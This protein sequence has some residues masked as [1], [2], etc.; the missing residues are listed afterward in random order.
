[1]KLSAL[2]TIALYATMLLLVSS[3]VSSTK[4]LQKGNYDAAIDKAVKVLLRKPGKFSEIET[5]KS[6]YSM[7]NR[8]DEETIRQLKISGQPDI[9]EKV[10]ELYTRL[11]HRQETVERLPESILPRI[12]FKHVDYS[13]PIV[14]SKNK[15][16]AYLDAHA[17]S[18]LVSG[19]KRDARQAYAEFLKV[20]EFF[21]NYQR[22]DSKIEQAY[23]QGIS[24][25]L[26]IFENDSRTVLPE[27]YETE[28]M[29]ISLKSL[30]EKWINFHTHQDANAQ[31]DYA[32]YLIVNNIQTTPDFLKE[33]DYKE[34]KKVNDGFE[35]V[36]DNNGNVMKDS[37]GNDIKIPKTKIIACYVAETEMRK[38]AVVSGSLEFYDRRTVEL[39]KTQPIRSEF[40]FHHRFAR[41][42]GDLAAMSEQTSQLIQVDPVPF[43]TDLQIIFDTNEDLKKQAKEII[44]S[45]KRLF[46]Y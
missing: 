38:Q 12:G 31:Y 39:I 29:K 35:Y 1:M 7:A 37:V 44:S 20:K 17:S 13:Q 27:D 8:K 10:L 5:L 26:F 19:S 28:M 33:R 14:E 24:H 23:Q 2:T 30:D 11:Q 16:A 25:V 36:F 43:P 6:A 18:L 22:I 9:F 15:A 34:E 42:N 21:P 4:Q 45:D 40:L 41:V 46:L 32:I 3:C